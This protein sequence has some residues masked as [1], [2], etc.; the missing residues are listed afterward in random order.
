[1]SEKSKKIGLFG[2]TFDPIH[3][4]HLNLAVELKE[5]RGLDEVWF[6]PAAINP[7]KAEFSSA[8][9][10][11][12][13]EMLKIALQDFPSFYVTDLE[14][15]RAPPSYTIETIREFYRLNLYENAHYFLLIGEDCLLNFEK[16]HQVE[17]IVK[18]ITLLIGS[19]LTEL[20]FDPLTHNTMLQ[21]A[22]QLGWTQT[23]LMD[24]SGTQLRQRLEKKLCCGH[25]IP[26]AVLQYIR[27]NHLYQLKG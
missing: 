5:K 11:H 3:V 6:I 25:L 24:I 16:W 14:L 4:G 12:R 27:Q 22:F 18:I 9:A 21:A 1:M 20:P 17:E 8:G 7:L 2:G 10:M 26:A 19:R 23:R 13:L 15:K